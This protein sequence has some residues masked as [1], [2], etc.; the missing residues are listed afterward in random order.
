MK[1]FFVSW[2]LGCVSSTPCPPGQVIAGN[3]SEHP[4]NSFNNCLSN[5]RRTKYLRHR[6]SFQIQVDAESFYND[7]SVAVG[8]QSV[9]DVYIK[10]M[11]LE[12]GNANYTDVEVLDEK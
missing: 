7:A 4:G 8:S 3:Y 6:R 1:I 10:K 9:G 5:L 11:K 2:I 12:T